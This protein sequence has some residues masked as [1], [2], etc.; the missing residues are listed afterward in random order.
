M[1]V[2]MSNSKWRVCLAALGAIALAGVGHPA[3]AA[4]WDATYDPSAF[5][6]TATFDVPGPCLSGVADGQ[7][8]QTD[9]VGCSP[10]RILA[11]VSTLPAVNFAAVLPSSAVTSYE[12]IGQQFVGVNTGVVG[13]VVVGSTDYWF[14][15]LSSFNP[16][17][18]E[19]FVTNTVNLYNDCPL[20]GA[21]TAN[22]GAPVNQATLVT[23][24]ARA[25][26]P[27]SLGLILG[28]IGAGWLARRRKA[29]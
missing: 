28:A 7:H 8:L 22:C 13:F 19:P 27:G 15:F 2:I 21:T 20:E 5:I 12:V 14:Q 11:N 26:E 16:G 17:D 3:Q 29:A 24:T 6:G 9:F 23:F 10:I 1:G 25:P 18:G 4:F